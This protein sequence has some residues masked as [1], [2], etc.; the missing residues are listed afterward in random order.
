[1]PKSIDQ[2][3]NDITTSG[4][5]QA[6][7]YMAWFS[8][9]K[10]AARPQDAEQLARELVRQRKLTR[11]QA[12]QIYAGKGKALTLGNYLILDKLGQGGMGMVLKA[13]HRR[14]DRTVAIKVMSA[15]GMKSPDAVQRFQR[16]VKAAAK[17]THPHIVAA[18][19]ADEANGTHFLVMEYVEGT[20]LSMYVK[21]HGPLSEERAV[22]WILQA[23]RGLKYAHQRGVVHRDIKPANLLL[24]NEGVVKL[25]DMGL[26]RIDGALSE[27]TALTCTGTVMGTV[28]YM[29]PE[30]ALSAKSADARSDIYSLG[31]SLWYLLT[32]RVA[33]EGDSTMAKLLAHRDAPLPSLGETPIDHVFRKMIAKR[34]EDRQQTMAEVISELEG[35]TTF[36]SSES[37]TFH[38]AQSAQDIDLAT[39][40]IKEDRVASKQRATPARSPSKSGSLVIGSAIGIAAMLLIGWSL[41]PPA[42]APSRPAPQPLP[43]KVTPQVSAEAG[44]V[45]LLALVDLQADVLAGTWTREKDGL[46]VEQ[47]NDPVHAA[48]I[49][50][51]YQP[52]E[53]YNFEI[54]FTPQSGEGM[55]SQI[56][57]R[58]SRLFSWMMNSV[59]DAGVKV[60][61]ESI[62]GIMAK[63]GKSGTKMR[64]E[65]L[66]NGSRYR[67]R[68]EVRKDVIR[69]Y[70]ND[71]LLV[72]WKGPSVR[73]GINPRDALR[74]NLH[75]GLSALDRAV[76]FHRIEVREVVGKGLTDR[77]RS[78]QLTVLAKDGQSASPQQHSEPERSSRP[79]ITVDADRRAA[80]W[81]LNQR[82]EVRVAF[83]DEVA[84]YFYPGDTLPT[85][86][87]RV[88][89]ISFANSEQS[90]ED[91]ELAC[92]VGLTDL[93]EL[94]LTKLKGF[95]DA[96]LKHMSGLTSLT[97]LIMFNNDEVTD[98]GIQHL[99]S[100][101]K[102]EEIHIVATRVS[103][104][105]LRVFLGCPVHSMS[106]GGR[107]VANGML[108]VVLE[109]EELQRLNLHGTVINDSE[110]HRLQKLPKLEVL[111]LLGTS[112]TDEGLKVLAS[113]RLS[114]L[115]LVNG[116]GVIS[117]T[118]LK[119]LETMTSLKRL[120]LSNTKTTATGLTALR[121]AL[122]NCEIIWSEPTQTNRPR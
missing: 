65:F 27:E 99:A 26:A 40:I 41:L 106:I 101:R 14:M 55:V 29:A 2:F 6:A 83:H 117:D 122:T 120:S 53:E 79:V 72:E 56:L 89:V 62:D 97:K 91:S 90:I 81:V 17:L 76:I 84:K 85:A 36:A 87:F 74:D 113:M 107:A 105:G 94:N 38:Q 121:N 114:D 58:E 52:P 108:P 112:I 39:M 82:G 24:S 48:R 49:Q 25:L 21:R 37:R 86:P 19:D 93:R 28:D 95:T 60:G 73:L 13:L 31:I 34:P 100:L 54:E 75:L 44:I 18:H 3:V 103:E 22:A 96:G 57:T 5:M 45:D 4:L 98:V 115:N 70:L 16:E 7:D 110:L 1:M 104:K 111:S 80:E 92:L 42:S 63:D 15:A 51:S 9:L 59:L 11:F 32:G 69:S 116:N 64:P 50:I 33:Y 47:R 61:F 66:V 46:R 20:D 109:F 71:E 35:I 102:L 88:R 10:E 30:Q 78:P 68:V 43:A 77:S 67:S 118:G 12:E 23:A 8:A 119:S